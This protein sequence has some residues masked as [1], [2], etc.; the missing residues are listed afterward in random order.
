[1]WQGHAFKM[2]LKTLKFLLVHF[3]NGFEQIVFFPSHHLIF[4]SDFAV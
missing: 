1:M 2:A 3:K 4:T